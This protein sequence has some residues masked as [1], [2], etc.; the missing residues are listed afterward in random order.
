MEYIIQMHAGKGFLWLS[1]YRPLSNSQTCDD[2][3]R[4]VSLLMGCDLMLRSEALGGTR[5]SRLHRHDG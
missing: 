2:S 5:A 3:E 1:Q 4:M